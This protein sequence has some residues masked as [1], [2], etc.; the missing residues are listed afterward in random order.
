MN[1]DL[2]TRT[3]VAVATIPADLI[4][5]PT[6]HAVKTI[7]AGYITD[8]VKCAPFSD[9]LDALA[10]ALQQAATASTVATAP[11]R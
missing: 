3:A 1:A 8:G 4:G 7:R 10:D 2:A 11:T 9:I 5:S 6:F